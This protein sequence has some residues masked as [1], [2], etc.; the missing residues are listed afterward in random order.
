MKKFDLIFNIA[1]TKTKKACSNCR[2]FG[3][4]TTFGG[5]NNTNLVP[6]DK[7]HSVHPEAFGLR[8]EKDHDNYYFYVKKSILERIFGL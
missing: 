8:Y 1:V 3:V 4:F 7:C 2:G 6:C 5:I